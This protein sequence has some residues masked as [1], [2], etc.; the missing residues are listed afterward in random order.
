MKEKARISVLFIGHFA[1]DTIIRFKEKRKPSLGGSVSFGSLALSKYTEKAN[2]GIISN[3][4]KQN[5]DPRLLNPLKKKKINISIKWFDTL[6]TNFI[7]NYVNHSRSLIL[8]S[9]SPNLDINDI[10][11]KIKENPPEIIVLVPL[12]NEITIEYVKDILKMFPEAYM[13]IDLQGFI[14]KIDPENGIVS[15]L[16]D[17]KLLENVKQLITLI[18]DKLILKGS[19]NEMK[20][21]SGKE[22][23]FEVMEFFNG[24]DN[25]GIYIMT[26]GEAGSMITRQ[27]EK[28][29][30]IPAFTP[31][32][33]VDETG[34]GDVYLAIFL[35]E[36]YNSDF[37]W[38]AIESAALY[39]SSAASFLV[40]KKGTNGSKS[41]KIVFKRLCQ[42]N[43]IA[44][45]G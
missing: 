44:E 35:Y 22:D 39:A 12:C 17:E 21:I 36:F 38:K 2:V 7:L 13:G 20:L 5:F 32:T 23:L 42:K 41:M 34:A 6:N 10:P 11:I 30:K 43:Y 14:R 40:E 37:S 19:E 8:K 15:Y 16:F 26:L 29:L 28:I 3:V 18:G 9:K 25:E 45:C 27:G 24:F 1:I 33:V 31:D 4:G